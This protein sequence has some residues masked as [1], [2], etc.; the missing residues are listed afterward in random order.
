MCLFFL[1]TLSSS[2]PSIISSFLLSLSL[3]SVFLFPRSDSFLFLLS[4]Q[5]DISFFSFPSLSLFLSLNHLFLSSSSFSTFISSF[6][7]LTHSSLS[8]VLI[9]MCLFF[10]STL[11]SSFSSIISFFLLSLSHCSLFLLPSSHPPLPSTF[12]A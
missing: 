6:H 1:P 10:L 8:E 4:T 9:F 3:C 11:S 7:V 12:S 5:L 2:F